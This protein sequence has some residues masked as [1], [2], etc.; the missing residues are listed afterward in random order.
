MVELN[1]ILWLY[2]KQEKTLC[3]RTRAIILLEMVH[4]D[5]IETG[6]PVGNGMVFNL[7]W[8][9]ISDDAVWFEIEKVGFLGHP[10][11]R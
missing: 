7:S 6:T 10:I 11:V 4:G 8:H 1:V 9:H 2:G 3:N 5:N